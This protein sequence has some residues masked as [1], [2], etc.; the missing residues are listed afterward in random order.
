MLKSTSKIILASAAA[1]MALVPM[2][3]QAKT[4]A[5]D[6]GAVYT[7]KAQASQPGKGRDTKG[8]KLSSGADIFA[9]T[10]VAL[11]AAGVTTAAVADDDPDQSPG[12]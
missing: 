8:Q 1:A 9:W 7:A 11:W 10:L 6:S 2:T 12:T 4:R 5:S 3:A